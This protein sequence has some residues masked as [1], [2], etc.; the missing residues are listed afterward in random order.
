MADLLQQEF[1]G[2]YQLKPG[3]TGEFTV[4]L[5]GDKLAEKTIDG[6]PSEDEILERVREKTHSGA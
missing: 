2:E 3:G 6:F 5:E 4:W 1:G